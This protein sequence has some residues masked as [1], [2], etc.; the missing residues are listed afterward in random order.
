LNWV[1]WS[2]HFVRNSATWSA[3]H[4]RCKSPNSEYDTYALVAL[5]LLKLGLNISLGTLPR[6][7]W[8]A[9]L[10]PFYTKTERS[11]LDYNGN[12]KLLVRLRHYNSR[13][14]KHY[15]TNLMG[16][17][18]SVN[19]CLWCRWRVR[20]EKPVSVLALNTGKLCGHLVIFIRVALRLCNYKFAIH[21]SHN[22]LFL[23]LEVV[24]N[25]DVDR[26]K[27]RLFL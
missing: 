1:N 21:F 9:H 5:M 8:Y 19:Q 7:E 17:R 20:R 25:W 26:R 16:K 23:C 12:E 24:R 13:K 22:T 11:I 10:F 18:R 27:K 2:R 15:T 3:L 6:P 4:K 14:W